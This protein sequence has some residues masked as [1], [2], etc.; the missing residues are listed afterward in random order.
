[1][2]HLRLEYSN[3]LNDFDPARAL[4]LASQ[5]MF[6][7]GLF[8]EADIKCRA[9]ACADYCIGVE[10]VPRAFMH[11]HVALMPGRSAAERKALAEALL[12]ALKPLALAAYPHEL[13]LSVETVELDK[14]S[15]AKVTLHG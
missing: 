13:Q 6:D 14:P 7:S 4:R 2:P 8:A 3:N 10:A 9:L 11:V 12:A 1:M 5:A 15:Y